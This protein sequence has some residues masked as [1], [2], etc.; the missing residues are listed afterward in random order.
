MEPTFIACSN[1]VFYLVSGN[2][3]EALACTDGAFTVLDSAKSEGA[4]EKHLP[5]VHKNGSRVEVRVG[6]VLHPMSAEHSIEWIFLETK[7]ADNSAIFRRT[8]NLLQNL[9][10]R[11]TMRRSRLMRTAI[12]T[13]SGKRSSK[14]TQTRLPHK[15]SRHRGRHSMCFPRC[16]C[17]RYFCIR[18][19]C[20]RLFCIRFFRI[21]CFRIRCFCIL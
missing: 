13:A 8:A 12:C 19:F 7:K 1:N 16:F 21:R 20:I 18:L 5:D 17:I 11:R 14:N 10:S 9:S 6:S 2:K 3:E 4:G 15:K